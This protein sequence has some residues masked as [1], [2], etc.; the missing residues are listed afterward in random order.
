MQGT[1]GGPRWGPASHPVVSL[2]EQGDGV[3]R[4]PSD[5]DGRNPSPCQWVSV[6]VPVGTSDRV[7]LQ[8]TTGNPRTKRVVGIEESG[9]KGVD[10]F[11]PLLS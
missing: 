2:S 6:R 10:P 9:V 7:L 5:P 8:V 3:Y 1:A 11:S 4:H